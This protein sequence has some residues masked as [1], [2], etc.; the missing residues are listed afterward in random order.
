MLKRTNI[1]KNTNLT[2]GFEHDVMRNHVD[3]VRNSGWSKNN[4]YDNFS[5]QTGKKP[6][7]EHIVT[8]MPDFVSLTYEFVVWTNFIEQ[9]NS[10]VESFVEQNNQY[11]GDSTDYKFLCNI[12]SISDASEMNAD[13]ERFIKSTFSVLTSAYILT[14][15]TNSVVTNV[16]SQTKKKLTPSKV[17][18]GYEGNATNKQVGK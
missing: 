6:V 7:Q 8:G 9:M 12:E 10:V 17:V 18:F 13:G 1:E 5:V 3:V 16:I 4:R 2:Q 14:E 11:W 15:Y